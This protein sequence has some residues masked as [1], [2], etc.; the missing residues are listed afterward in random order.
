L[1]SEIGKIFFV[2]CLTLYLYKVHT[3]FFTTMLLS[4]FKF[5]GQYNNMN[6]FKHAQKRKPFRFEFHSLRNLSSP[7]DLNNERKIYSG[8]VPLT[9]II[10][11]PTDENVRNYL[12]ES[13][14]KQKRSYTSVHKAIRDSLLNGSENFT[15]LNSGVVIV[16]RDVLV[17]EKEKFINLYEPSIINGAQT[18]GVIKDLYD[19]GRLPENTH[20]KFEII[21]TSDEGLIAEISIARNFQ[22]DV[23][24]VSIAGRL[25]QFDE[26]EKSIQKVYPKYTLRKSESEYPNNGDI[27]DTEKLLQVITA[28][29]PQEL[30]MKSGESEDPN[31]VYTYSMKA[32][33]LKE[34]QDIIK[35]A[36]DK[37]DPENHRYRELYKFYLDVASS[38][39]DLY[40]LWKSH[41]GFARTGL[42]SIERNGNEIV[43]VPDGIVFPIISSLSV[44][45][46]KNNRNWILDIPSNRIDKILIDTAKRTYMEIA[47]HNPQTM[48]K[49]KACYSSLLQI[50][51]LYKDLAG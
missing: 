21:V 16:A 15:V 40:I 31:K 46:K 17:D 27:I 43:E 4:K 7:E 20:I 25:G 3:N 49:S 48:G 13:T 41:Q 36:K 45:S 30:W 51:N 35:R 9:A 11:L 12:P 5:G 23:M 22:N 34:F 38:A 18:Q 50:T 28:L 10:D 6:N 39:W 1:Q 37:D 32:R 14:G 29:V 8:Q 47:K 24:A 33:C 19:E 2:L 44:F 42:R 26:L